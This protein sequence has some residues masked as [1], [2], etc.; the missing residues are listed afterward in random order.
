[1]NI[2]TKI[3]ST[4]ELRAILGL[5][6]YLPSATWT[7]EPVFCM[8]P[9]EEWDALCPEGLGNVELTM[10]EQFYEVARNETHVC[11]K[12]ANALTHTTSEGEI[13]N[14]NYSKTCFPEDVFTAWLMHYGI[15]SFYMEC[16]IEVVSDNVIN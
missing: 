4:E 8:V 16:P 14:G 15:E 2:N 13:P 12:T 10:S 3:S 6:N 1:M 7:G 9:I 5:I 11:T